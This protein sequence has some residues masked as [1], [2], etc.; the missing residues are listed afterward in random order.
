MQEEKRWEPLR[1]ALIQ[2]GDFSDYFM[3]RLRYAENVFFKELGYVPGSKGSKHLL[4]DHFLE[5]WR[6]SDEFFRKQ[7][8]V[9]NG[10]CDALNDCERC[11]DC[12]RR[13]KTVGI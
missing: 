1:E 9:F 3:E 10:A 5:L 12:I 6:L 2:F 13:Y 11:R 7:T 4:R 8:G